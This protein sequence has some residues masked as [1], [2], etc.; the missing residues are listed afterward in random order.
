MIARCRESRLAARG[1]RV[2]VILLLALVVLCAAPSAGKR[3][4]SAP[5]EFSRIISVRELAS[6]EL[7]V[8]DD[9]ENRIVL[10]DSRLGVVRDV[11]QVG[12]GP[13]EFRRAG[14]L[15]AVGTDSTIAVDAFNGRALLLH[16]GSVISVL[17][18]DHHAIQAVGLLIVGGDTDG[19]VAGLRTSGASPGV[20][21][22]RRSA[23]LL[24][25]AHLASG[26][27]DTLARLRGSDLRINRSSG[28]RDDSF[29]ATGI[30]FSVPEQAVLFAD[31]RLAVARLD[32]YRVEWLTSD[33]NV[34]ATARGAWSPPPV[35]QA[36][37]D[38]WR[39][40]VLRASSGR[41]QPDVAAMDWAPN[42]SPYRAGGLLSTP[43]GALVVHRPEWSGSRGNEYDIYQRASTEPKFLRLPRSQRI[44]GFG[45]GVA[46]V[47]ESDEDG[48]ERLARM[49]WAY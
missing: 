15:I 30:A 35:T 33:G 25:R 43:S 9:I 21:G 44:V 20:G 14:K 37:K 5:T 6:G 16:N 7:L 27:V 11:A 32:P 48:V 39:D 17:A 24:V 29:T 2:N 23:L 49:P 18:A 28:S 12:S 1:R 41:I 4:I 40:R 36:E 34:E 46:Y 10:L 26:R 31:G 42:V 38:A 22:S 13:G 19:F 45:R 47:A 3:P 8:S